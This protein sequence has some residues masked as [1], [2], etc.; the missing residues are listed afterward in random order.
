[1]VNSNRDL[2]V[3]D[4][5]N[6]SEAKHK[7]LGPVR[8]LSYNSNFFLYFT[9]AYLLDV[10]HSFNKAYVAFLISGYSSIS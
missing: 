10:F 7:F 5:M 4:G 9:K 6:G 1:M 2:P 8:S 3:T